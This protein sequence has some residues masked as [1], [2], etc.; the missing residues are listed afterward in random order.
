MNIGYLQLD[1]DKFQG[2]MI[3]SRKLPVFNPVTGR[4]KSSTLS[5]KIY[6]YNCNRNKSNMFYMIAKQ[7]RRWGE[8]RLYHNLING[9]PFKAW[10]MVKHTKLK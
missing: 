2:M 1:V 8:C 6:Y 10:Y 5:G 3:G 9:K 7:T 4:K